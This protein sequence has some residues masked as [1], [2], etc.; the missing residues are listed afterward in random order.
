M[1]S[2][3]SR[4]QQFPDFYTEWDF[5][6]AFIVGIPWI[7]KKFPQKKPHE[8]FKTMGK[9]VLRFDQKRTIFWIHLATLE[10]HNR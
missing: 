2:L 7:L 9:R 6:S 8:F 3:H 4:L 10:L 5:L 1:R